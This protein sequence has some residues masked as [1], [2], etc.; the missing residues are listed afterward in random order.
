MAETKI[1]RTGSAEV[2]AGIR[3]AIRNNEL[4][5]HERLASERALSETYGVSRGTVREALTKLEK[6]GLVEIRPGSGTYITRAPY[7]TDSSAIHGARPLELI[8][9]RFALEPHI[10]RLAVL[11]ARPPDFQKMENFLKIMEASL[12]DHRQFGEADTGFH[13]ALVESTGNNLLMWIIAQINSVRG[14]DEWSRMRQVTLDTRIIS[15]YNA[16]HRF[17]FEAIRAREPEKAAQFMKDHLETARLSL[18]R[19]ADT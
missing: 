8:D 15:R 16:Q 6:E 18:T 12:D 7:D 9:T 17:I 3:R 13:T 1:D 2:A 14:Q 19:A 11:H 4:Q 5:L 10:C